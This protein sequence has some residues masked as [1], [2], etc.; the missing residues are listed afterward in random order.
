MKLTRALF[1]HAWHHF[2]RLAVPRLVPK[3]YSPGPRSICIQLTYKCNLRCSFCGQWGDTGTF[4]SL[5]A[6]QLRQM[7][8]LSVLQ[9]VIDELHLT[10]QSVILWGGET[11]DYP[12]IVPL[13]RYVKESDRVCSL[14]TNGT[15]LARYARP[16]VESGT[17][18][19]EVSLDGGET[20]HDALRG[21]RGTFRAALEGIRAL[22]AERSARSSR[23]PE[24]CVNATLVPAAVGELPALIRQLRGEGVD[25]GSETPCPFR[26]GRNHSHGEQL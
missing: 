17:D 16:L 11:L 2:H 3:G 15:H 26:P 10:C 9:R 23:L 12:E 8:P 20:T 5:P 6:D 25:P 14:V 1:F 4:K 7:L 22:K 18:I 24:I 13:V 19:I 21:A